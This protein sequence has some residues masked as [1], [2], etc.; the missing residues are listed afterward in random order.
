MCCQCSWS[1]KD[2]VQ[3]FFFSGYVFNSEPQILHQFCHSNCFDITTVPQSAHP[4]VLSGKTKIFFARLHD[5]NILP[6]CYPDF[7]L[8]TTAKRFFVHRMHLSQSWEWVRIL[9]CEQAQNGSWDAIK[10]SALAL[11]CKLLQPFCSEIRD[12][13]WNNPMRK[14]LFC[15]VNKQWNPKKKPFF[16]T[17]T[18]NSLV[19]TLVVTIEWINITRYLF[20]T[21]ILWFFK[22]LPSCWRTKQSLVPVSKAA[23]T[24]YLIVMLHTKRVTAVSQECFNFVD[25][26]GLLVFFHFPA[27][28]PLEESLQSVFPILRQNWRLQNWADSI[29]PNLSP[30]QLR[31]NIRAFL[32][33][34]NTATPQKRKHGNR[35][36]Q[37][38]NWQR[39]GIQVWKVTQL[40]KAK[41][42]SKSHQKI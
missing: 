25:S 34:S 2:R 5:E 15:R 17:Q 22:Y 18:L 8:S 1:D 19:F 24:I 12:D 35:P 10:M 36:P 21:A 42:T 32:P 14:I 6:E 31:P 9:G 3:W 41:I 27:S 11:G 16:S 26:S 13:G 20:H 38:S 7:L 29:S 37:W 39:N 30:Q 28:C 23:S 33:A 40:L 4:E